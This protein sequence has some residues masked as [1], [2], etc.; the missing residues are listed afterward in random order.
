[1]LAI[2][3]GS[4]LAQLPGLESASHRP[5]RTPYGEPSGAIALGKL[6]GREVMFL[7]RHGSAHT[8]P[9]HRINYRANLWSLREQ[10]AHEIVAVATVGG[11][12]A[13]FVPGT[14]AAPDQIIDYTHGR[15]ATFFD[16]TEGSVMHGARV[17]HS[18]MGA[19]TAARKD[20]ALKAQEKSTGS[21]AMVAIWWA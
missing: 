20:R 3:G 5:V 14:L 17:S 10:G 6:D 8:I 12:G 9:P 4:G 19:F 2:I 11:I 13:S 15:D 18:M 7:A 16:G 21:R 1:M